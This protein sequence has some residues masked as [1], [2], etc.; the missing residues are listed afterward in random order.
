MSNRK[1]DIIIPAYN[2][3]GTINRTLASIASQAIIDDLRVIIVNDASE[4]DYSEFIKYYSKFFSVEEIKCSENGGPGVARQLGID[5]SS[6]PYI[7]FIDADDTFAGAFALRQLRFQLESNPALCMVSSTFWEE[8]LYPDGI[9]RYHQHVNDMVWMFGKMYKRAFIE[10]M[11]IRFNKSRA[12][13]DNGFN[14]LIKL[15]GNEN[16]KVGFCQDVTYYWHINE[17]SITRINNCEYSYNQSFPGYTDNMIYAI[18]EAKKRAPFN[19]YIKLFSIE[20]MCNLYEYYIETLARDKRF[21]E[22]NLQACV[23]FYNEI[24]KDIEKDITDEIFSEVYN[25][26]MQNVY[27]GN[28]MKGIIPAIGIK[29]FMSQISSY[30]YEHTDESVLKPL[31]KSETLMSC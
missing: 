17:N 8:Q 30:E 15:C 5:H 28:R 16:A 4:K 20:V 6:N 23:K 10:G 27:M 9:H 31:P 26:I 14:T 21:A 3:H 19:G 18:T 22:Q 25:K 11:N 2:A 13:E 7:T 24:Y 1:I 12:N 29:E